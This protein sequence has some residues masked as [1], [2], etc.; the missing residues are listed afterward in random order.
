MARIVASVNC[1]HVP[2][3]GTG[4]FL[5]RTV[6]TKAGRAAAIVTATTYIVNPFTRQQGSTRWNLCQKPDPQQ[7]GYIAE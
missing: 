4:A 6:Q 7:G 1:S 2:A 3:I 5:G